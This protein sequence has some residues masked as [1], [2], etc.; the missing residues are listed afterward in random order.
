MGSA[1]PKSIE[2]LLLGCVRGR[3][4]H[5]RSSGETEFRQDLLQPNRAEP[6]LQTTETIER[7]ECDVKKYEQRFGNSLNEDVKV[8]V[9][10]ALAQP[11]VQKD[12][13]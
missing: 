2:V 9:T 11:E 5:S 13:T 1:N 8:G 10:R 7:W 4:D 3:Q 12:C 6:I